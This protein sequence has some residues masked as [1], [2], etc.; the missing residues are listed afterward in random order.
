MYSFPKTNTN[1]RLVFVLGPKRGLKNGIRLCLVL[2][3]PIKY[4]PIDGLDLLLDKRGG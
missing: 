2:V 3:Y 1:T 4:D